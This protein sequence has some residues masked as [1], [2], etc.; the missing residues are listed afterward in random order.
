MYRVLASHCIMEACLSGEV[1]TI[2]EAKWTAPYLTC[3]E[4][5]PGQVIHD[6]FVLC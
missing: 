1:S 6:L 4:N 5:Y 2:H 3:Y